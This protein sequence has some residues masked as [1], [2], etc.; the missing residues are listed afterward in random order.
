MKCPVWLEQI[1]TIQ[2]KDGYIVVGSNCVDYERA[3]KSHK[4][5]QGA[6]ISFGAAPKLTPASALF[7]I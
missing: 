5:P 4:D 6:V 1:K 2:L 7:F 3:T